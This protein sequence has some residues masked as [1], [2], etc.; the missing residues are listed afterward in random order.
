MYALR[1]RRRTVWVWRDVFL[2]LICGARNHLFIAWVNF[3]ASTSQRLASWHLRRDVIRLWNR[4]SHKNYFYSNDVTSFPLNQCVNYPQT[5][6]TRCFGF[7][8]RR[9]KPKFCYSFPFTG[10]LCNRIPHCRLSDCY[11]H[12]ISRE[13][14]VPTTTSIYKMENAFVR[15]CEHGSFRCR[16]SPHW[17]CV[18]FPPFPSVFLLS[19]GRPC[20][21]HVVLLDN[22]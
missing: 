19:I 16:T 2:I 12:S 4:T 7:V 13:I 1:C 5:A 21:S 22:L 20:I 3:I 9:I 17:V 15:R 8:S 18:F 6:I 11:S 10:N 14:L